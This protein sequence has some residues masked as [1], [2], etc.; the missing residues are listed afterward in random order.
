MKKDNFSITSNFSLPTY[1]G[2]FC[3]RYYDPQIGRFI[4]LDPVDDK[5][6]TS[7]YAYCDNNPLKFNDPT[8]EKFSYLEMEERYWFLKDYGIWKAGQPDLWSTFASWPGSMASYMRAHPEFYQLVLENEVIGEILRFN[9]TYVKLK[10]AAEGEPWFTGD[11]KLNKKDIKEAIDWIRNNMPE[12]VSE[13]LELF[14][15]E[16]ILTDISGA[17]AWGRQY[18]NPFRALEDLFEGK[19]PDVTYQ[20]HINSRLARQ[21]LVRIITHET[22][23]TGLCRRWG[24]PYG[25]PDSPAHYATIRQTNLWFGNG[26]GW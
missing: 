9:A 4:T 23:E 3:Q 11:R 24:I 14:N 2:Y 13:N 10:I 1:Y 8:G 15:F 21:C 25:I 18:M 19:M 17:A 7:P 16:F 22:W 20:I 12:A 6:G 26:W 5:K